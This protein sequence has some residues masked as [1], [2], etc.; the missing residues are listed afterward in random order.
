MIKKICNTFFKNPIRIDCLIYFAEF[1]SVQSQELR[2]NSDNVYYAG[3]EHNLL[4]Q[5]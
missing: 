1:N 2:R 5:R 4:N 3:V